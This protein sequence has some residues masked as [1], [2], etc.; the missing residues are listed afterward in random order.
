ML[1]QTVTRRASHLLQEADSISSFGQEPDLHEPNRIS[2]TIVENSIVRYLR[3]STYQRQLGVAITVGILCLALCSFLV[4]SWQG[5]QRVRRN[6]L[7]QGEHITEN[8][9]HQS[10]LALLTGS[11][12]NAV[13][14]VNATQTFPG[15]VRVEIHDSNDRVLLARGVADSV[16]P[17]PSTDATGQQVG[18]DSETD[19]EWHFS[20]PVYSQ[21][22][23][24]SPFQVQQA[25]PELLGYVTVVVSKATLAHMTRDMFFA[26]LITSFSFA[27]LFLFLIRLLTRHMTRP[28][29]QLSTA[30]ARAEEGEEGVRATPS[31]P[32]D[33]AAMAHAFN[34][35]MEVLEERKAEL[36]DARDKAL[37]FARLK[38]EFAAIVSHEVRTP[39]NGVIGMLDIL[40]ATKLPRQQREFVDVAWSSAHALLDL[41]NDILDFSKLEAGKLALEQVDFAPTQLIEEVI[42]LFSVGAHQ[43]GLELGYLTVS[44]VP[45]RVCGDP[46]RLRQVLANLIGNAVK[47]THQ[48]EVAITIEAS[49]DIDQITPAIDSDS[50]Q[51][52]EVGPAA[53]VLLRFE[54]S[55]TGIGIAPAAQGQ[56]FESFAQADPS[57]TR[58]YGGTGLGLAISRQL[59]QLMGGEIGIESE[60][61]CGSRFWF[62]LPLRVAVAPVEEVEIP[63]PWSVLLVEE[64]T[65]IRDFLAQSLNSW[66]SSTTAAY[67]TAEALITLRTAVAQGRPFDLV[68]TDVA[69]VLAGGGELIR[70]IRNDSTLAGTRTILME[71]FGSEVDAEVAASWDADAYLAKPLHLDRLRSCLVGLMEKNVEFKTDHHPIAADEESLAVSYR[72]LIVEDNRTNQAVAVGMLEMLGC[73]GIPVASGREALE[74]LR[75]ET[76]D[77]VLMDCNM[78]EMDGYETT[79]HIREFE[80]GLARGEKTRTPIIAM[81]ANTRAVDVERCL[82]AGMDDHLG[83]PFTLDS[84]A[85]KIRHWTGHE[86]SHRPISLSDAATTAI[87]ANQH[88]PLDRSVL[89]TLREALGD[90]FGQALQPFLEDTPVYMD[91]LAKGLLTGNWLEVR[92][93]AHSIKGSAGNLGAAHFSMLAK[94]LE[95]FA[96][97]ALNADSFAFMDKEERYV[98][99]V[100]Y[101]LREEY[102]QVSQVL[103][104]EIQKQVSVPARQQQKSAL[105][106]V[107]DDD[108]STRAALRYALQRDGFRV[109]EASDGM[110]ALAMVARINPDVVLMDAVMPVMD[111]FTACAKLQEMPGGAELPVLIVTALEDT[112]SIERAFAAGARDYI[113]KP[114]H[115]TV[116]SQRVRRIVET[117]QSERHVRRLAYNDTLTGLANRLMFMDHLER[118]LAHAK[119]NDQQLAVLFLDLDR[120][121]FVNDTMGHDVGDRLLVSVARRI[122]HCVRSVDCVARFGGDEFTISLEELTNPSAAVVAAQKVCRALTTPFNINGQELFVSTSIGISIF[123]DDGTEVSTLL[124]HADTAMYRAKKNN[125]GYAFYEPEMESSLSAHLQTENALRHA[126]ERNELVVFYQPKVE[127]ATWALSGMEALIRWQHPQWGLV[128]PAEFIPIAED[129]G[130]ILPIGEWVLRAACAQLKSWQDAGLSVFPVAVNLSS[131][132]IKQPDLVAIV[133]DTLAETGIDPKMLEL[134]ITESVL[135]EQAK[136]TLTTLHK[137]KEIGVTLAID[138]FG[139]GYSSLSYLKRFPVDTLKIDRAFVRD[140]HTSQDDASIVTS[141]IAL[142]HS[143]RRTVVAEGVETVQQREF[144]VGAG[145]DYIQ[146]YLLAEPLPPELFESWL[147][148]RA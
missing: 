43:K 104:A 7:E 27:L 101:K 50:T 145:C 117:S 14:A 124:K 64:S 80:G 73:R 141:I 114:V 33:I 84:L 108:R 148:S 16:P 146:G 62:T 69:F 70:N 135:M 71:R 85:A 76:F 119:N 47:F 3:N 106:L 136:E 131:L 42:D 21:R 18:L 25:K 22:P 116:V 66:G 93:A 44:S 38:A 32:S 49:F 103:I 29:E 20:A 54:V 24:D 13:E 61:G 45:A 143:L 74:L 34:N 129:T 65:I 81:T 59:V 1:Q 99:E 51:K 115:L 147:L 53:N 41:I 88:E 57:T 17:H 78:P 6:L 8:L 111:G 137:L 98:E 52:E 23:D 15:V 75:G 133:A 46:Q 86:V 5:T 30:M 90:T 10:V 96:V 118:R 92:Q 28:L 132:Q 56:L 58:K 82:A 138:D 72:V 127:V 31:G 121:K 83:K 144:L 112:G 36:R 95:D 79:T 139:T 40:K 140:V 120:F 125:T 128:S 11:P 87:T 100:L 2:E 126:L 19:T 12:E 4:S 130:L 134:E 63:P 113:P 107:V 105:V 48:G 91:R 35:M 142:A 123:P 39:M 68:I 122:K 97:S 89:A 60:I 67:S 94:Q 77:L 37:A 55:D 9:A 102:A 109:D 26:N 110:Q